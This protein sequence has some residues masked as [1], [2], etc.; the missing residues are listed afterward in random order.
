MATTFTIDARK[1]FVVNKNLGSKGGVLDSAIQDKL[2]GSGRSEV[3]D[4]LYLKTLKNKKTEG[5]LAEVMAP[6][7]DEANQRIDAVFEA[8]GGFLANPDRLPTATMAGGSKKINLRLLADSGEANL[9]FNTSAW[10]P[11]SKSYMDRIRRAQKTGSRSSDTK[12]YWYE[13]AEWANAK[14]TPLHQQLAGTAFGRSGSGKAGLYTDATD[15]LSK[16]AG[17]PSGV[18]FK[19]GSLKKGGTALAGRAVYSKGNIAIGGFRG[20][21]FLPTSIETG[22]NNSSNATT[23]YELVYG[24]LAS[25]K[26]VGGVIKLSNLGMASGTPPDLLQLLLANESRRPFIAR[27][28]AK[29]YKFIEEGLRKLA[30]STK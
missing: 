25:T 13:R 3:V 21:I 12:K 2:V 15:V 19:F 24:S 20:T 5:V 23:L 17:K 22:S 30:L 11:L 10:A 29:S 27:A 16:N 9:Q 4:L 26:E 14:G 28:F 6:L 1:V 7:A 18:T 8:I